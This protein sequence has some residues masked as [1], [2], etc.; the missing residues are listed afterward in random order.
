MKP[1]VTIRRL[2]DSMTKAKVTTEM[3][4]NVG[5]LEMSGGRGPWLS[6]SD[7]D[8]SMAKLDKKRR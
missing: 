7:S 2:P 5:P 3:V 6:I 1:R 8:Q 4:R